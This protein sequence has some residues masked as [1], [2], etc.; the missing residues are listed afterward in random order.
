MT[1]AQLIEKLLAL[2]LPDSYVVWKMEIPIETID[3]KT[4]S[5]TNMPVVNLGGY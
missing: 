5:V 2:N 4:N 1:V 3:V